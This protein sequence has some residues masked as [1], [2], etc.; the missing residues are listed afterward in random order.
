VAAPLQYLPAEQ[1][2]EKKNVPLRAVHII[3][4]ST[5]A[6]LTALGMWPLKLREDII[7]KEVLVGVM[8]RMVTVRV[9]LMLTKLFDLGASWCSQD[10][11]ATKNLSSATFSNT[12]LAITSLFVRGYGA[13]KALCIT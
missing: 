6:L 12:V 2:A 1:I 5:T 4:G 3:C 9:K 10:V 13:A 7:S 11:M 8:R